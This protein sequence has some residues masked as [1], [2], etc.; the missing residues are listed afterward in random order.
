MV[1]FF[2]RQDKTPC[3]HNGC[4]LHISNRIKKR[5]NCSRKFAKS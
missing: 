2:L 4:R 5:I 3:N 1:Y